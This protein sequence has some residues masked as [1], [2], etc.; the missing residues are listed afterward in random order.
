[1][2]VWLKKPKIKHVQSK[3]LLSQ[4]EA[5]CR[6]WET[7]SGKQDNTTKLSNEGYK[8]ITTILG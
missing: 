7:Q 8:P 2:L 3:P 5:E 1:M 4:F 6:N